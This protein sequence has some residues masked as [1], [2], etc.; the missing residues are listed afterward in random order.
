MTT[1]QT[2]NSHLAGMAEETWEKDGVTLFIVK[3]GHYCG[4]CRFAERPVK[5]QEYSGFLDYV[6]VH[7][8]ITYAVQDEGGMVY[9]F[10]CAHHLDA[11]DPKCSDKVWLRAECEKMAAGIRAAAIF[12]DRYLSAM[13]NEAKAKIIDEY[14]EHM[15]RECEARFDLRDN[16]GAMLNLLSGS[17]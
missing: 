16:F 13:T 3:Y 12:E 9:G 7:G 10:D 11:G 17:L 5:E 14:H 15:E 1:E 8:G 2:R 6:P 4:Y